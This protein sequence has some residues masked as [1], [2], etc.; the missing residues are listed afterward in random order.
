VKKFVFYFGNFANA[1]K[2]TKNERSL[3]WLLI[4]SMKINM[5]SS[6]EHQTIVAVAIMPGPLRNP[7]TLLAPK[8]TRI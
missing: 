7:I 4:D 8:S 2:T 1:P 6:L 5:L 3:A